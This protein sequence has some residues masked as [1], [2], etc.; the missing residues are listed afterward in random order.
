MGTPI[1]REE[2][3]WK[4]AGAIRAAGYDSIFSLTQDAAGTHNP[5]P[6]LTRKGGPGSRDTRKLEVK[7]GPNE[8]DAP[9]ADEERTPTWNQGSRNCKTVR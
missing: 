7:F 5:V 4:T 2:V 8:P 3:F 6:L 9:M 1:S